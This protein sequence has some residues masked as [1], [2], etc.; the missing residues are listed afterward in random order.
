VARRTVFGPATEDLSYDEPIHVVRATGTWL[1]DTA[2]RHYLDCY[3]N[4]PCVGHAHPRVT[5]AIARQSRVLNTNLRYLH[6]G[7]IEL[8]ERLVAT[9]PSELDTV[10]FVNS[11]SEAN[12]L[13]W[14]LATTY[15]GNTGGL[16]TTRAYHGISAVIAPLSPET[17]P[18]E[19]IRA[20][21][22]GSPPTPTAACTP[23][24]RRSVPR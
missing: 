15:T 8:A 6:A 24:A 23:T 17:L 21:S 3:N 12:D 9:C 2:N 13:A 14:R 11:G 7:A 4:V 5:E 19:A 1:V 18:P 22:A 20:S 10:F 16:C